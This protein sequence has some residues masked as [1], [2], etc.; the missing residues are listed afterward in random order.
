MYDSGCGLTAYDDVI[1][2]SN[3][4]QKNKRNEKDFDGGSVADKLYDLNE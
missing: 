2:N 1:I 3:I 4:N